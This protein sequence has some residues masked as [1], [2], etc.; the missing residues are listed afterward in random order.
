MGDD[1][2]T[3]MHITNLRKHMLKS[4]GWRYLRYV[5]L[6]DFISRYQDKLNV[7]CAAGSGLCFAETALALEFPR[8]E[9]F[10]TDIVCPGRPNYFKSMD[11]VTR[12]SIRNVRFGVWDL[13]QKS[14]Q[15]FD[16]VV[17]TEVLEHIQDYAT[18]VT[19]ML[20]AS[21]VATYALVPF[22]T[23]E[24]NEDAAARLDAYVKHEH[25]VCGY[26]EEHFGHFASR[27]SNFIGTYWNQSG[28]VFRRRLA[29]MT[30]ADID[31]QYDNLVA[32]AVS[33]LTNAAP[34]GGQCQGM[35]VIFEI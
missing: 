8:I 32:E 9:F 20:G 10:L 24:R 12:W 17:S 22:A 3:V 1:A 31:D 28:A 25:F 21:K 23:K 15:R 14:A 2:S 33:D 19:N 27:S 11:L 7:V 34:V 5:H 16:A 6:R 26:N 30:D 4:K 29:A 18:P 13:M 35:K